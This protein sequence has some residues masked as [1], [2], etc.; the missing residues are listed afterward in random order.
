M[1][2][3]PPIIAS[4]A[5]MYSRRNILPDAILSLNGQVD[6]LYVYLNDYPRVTDTL[7][8]LMKRCRKLVIHNRVEG[9]LSDAAKFFNTEAFAQNEGGA[10]HFTF[11][12]DLVYRPGYVDIMIDKI[13]EYN[14]RCVVGL[15]GII[16]EDRSRSYLYDRLKEIN[17]QHSNP[18]DVQVCILKTGTMAYH[19]SIDRPV[20]MKIFEMPKMADLFFARWCHHRAKPMIVIEHKALEARQN[21]GDKSDSI[22]SQI[23]AYAADELYTRVINQT[24]WHSHIDFTLERKDEISTTDNRI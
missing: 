19:T 10:Y 3:R 11:D 17:F 7:L 6:R 16:F 13:E 21:I 5:S 24:K 22:T 15:G 14:R 8:K 20:S 23:K 9:D 18:T 4:C 12:D 1:S 2:N